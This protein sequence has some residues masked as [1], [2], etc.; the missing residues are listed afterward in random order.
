MQ[1][2]DVRVLSAPSADSA[3]VGTSADNRVHVQLVGSSPSAVTLVA[4]RRLT[5]TGTVVPNG[6]GLTPGDGATVLAQ[7]TQHV[8]VFAGAVTAS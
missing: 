3:W 2:Q 7:Q 5:F 6:D 8:E 1:A 4:G